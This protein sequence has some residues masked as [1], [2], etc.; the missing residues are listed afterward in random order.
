MHPAT[1]G[2][3]QAAAVSFVT[4][5]LASAWFYAT[6]SVRVVRVM[7]P[8]IALG[9]VA[10]VTAF[11]VVS[12]VVRRRLPAGV[13]VVGAARG[14]AIGLLVVAVSAAVHALFTPGSAGLF[15]SVIGQVGWVCVVLGGPAAALGAL[16]GRL[17]ERRLRPRG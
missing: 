8:A 16:F 10:A 9:A 6:S 2:A 3:A 7:T 11:A 5:A 14:A 1:R 13:P 12:A 17:I 15:E 4:V